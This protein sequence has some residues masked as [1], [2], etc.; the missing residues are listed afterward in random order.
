MKRLLAATLGAAMLFASAAVGAAPGASAA[1]D[2][3]LTAALDSSGIDTLNPFLAYFD[4][5]LNTFGMIYP[6]LNQ[7]DR[8]GKPGPYLAKSWT[9]SADKLTWT[10]KIQSGLK[11]SDGQPLTAADAAWT[12][13]LIMTNSDAATANGSLVSNFVSVTAPDATTLVIKTKGPQSNMLYVSVPISGIAI[14]PEH[15]WKTHVS[16]V[17]AFKNNSFPVVGYGP[18]TLNNY[19]VDQYEKFT[20]NKGFKLG[21][22]GPPKYD[23]LVLQVFKNSDA[24]VAALKSNQ[25]NYL[26]GMNTTQFNALKKDSSLQ[27]FQEVGR[28]WT[29]VELNSGAKTKS[30][31]KIGTGNPAL[32]DP[33]LRQAI[34]FAIDKDKLVKTVIGGLGVA[35]GAYLPPAFPQWAWKPPADQA[36]T[37]DPGKANSILDAAGYKKGSGGIRVDPKT[38]KKLNLRLGI[39]S[40]SSRDSQTSQFLKGWLKSIGIDLKIESQSMTNLNVNLAKGDWDM[41]MDSWGTPADP[42]YLLSIQTCGTLPKDDGTGGNTDAFYCNPA[43]DKLFDQ[44]VTTFDATQRQQIVGQMQDILY[45]ANADIILYYANILDAVRKGTVSNLVTGSPDSAGLYT[46]QTAFW[47]Y[48]DASPGGG[49]SSGKSSSNSA[50]LYGGI[51][52][53]V[54]VLIGGGLAL[55]RRSTATE[56]E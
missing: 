25:I 21:K 35:G 55:R 41:L 17:K 27:V 7:L 15:I 44:Q 14:V 26:N 38:G 37:Y 50:L 1:S 33:K 47:N 16:N 12:L 18:W 23:K 51:A 28:G 49:K 22:Q 34:N 4:G 8:Q 6:S 20:A 36:V 43:Y 48:L 29:A 3:T 5:A 32:T 11:W 56:R 10:F 40:D 30:G 42:T 46:S 24:A 39:H 2:K 19:T 45:N 52:L 54:V 53:V 13:N 9:T 31:K